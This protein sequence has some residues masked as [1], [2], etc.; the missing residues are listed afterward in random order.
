MCILTRQIVAELIVIAAN[1]KMMMRSIFRRKLD[2]DDKTFLRAPLDYVQQSALTR[3]IRKIEYLKIDI[4]LRKT[5]SSLLLFFL[6][7][8]VA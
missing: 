6:P 1:C 3:L 4:L 8:A 5:I 7:S 2:F